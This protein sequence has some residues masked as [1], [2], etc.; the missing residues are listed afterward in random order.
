MAAGVGA[1]FC[2]ANACGGWYPDATTQQCIDIHLYL[3]AMTWYRI[4]DGEPVVAAYR[5]AWDMTLTLLSLNLH[6]DD[7]RRCA[8]AGFAGDHA[9][10]PRTYTYDCDGVCVTKYIVRG[11]HVLLNASGGDLSDSSHLQGWPW[12][13]PTPCDPEDDYCSGIVLSYL[14]QGDCSF[15]PWG[16]DRCTELIPDNYWLREFGQI[17]YYN[18]AVE[19]CDSTVAWLAKY[20]TGTANQYGTQLKSCTLGADEFCGGGA[21]YAKDWS[22][23]G[24]HPNEFPLLD[25]SED[26][27]TCTIPKPFI[28]SIVPGSIC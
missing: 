26:L 11:Y 19:D 14:I 25:C 16:G 4:C 8:F 20:A 6:E 3:P 15:C 17:A 2:C 28:V 23:G 12:E 1:S 24:D 21:E 5:E 9:S 27:C 13:I 18:N 10:N 22:A 7:A